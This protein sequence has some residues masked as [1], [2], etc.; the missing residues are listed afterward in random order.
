M[1]ELIEP[2]IFPG[3]ATFAFP[4]PA[5]RIEVATALPDAS[6]A[7]R[8]TVLICHPH[9]LHGGTMQNKVVTTTERALREL[10][11][12]TVRFNFRGVGSSE[13]TYDEGR[14]ESADALELAAWIQRVRPGDALWLAGFSFGSF[15]ALKAAQS[16]PVAQLVSIAPPV[17]RYE[18]THLPPP[19]CPWLV[20]MGD[21]DDVVEPE[22]VFAWVETLSPKPTLER[23]AGAGHFF[24][25]RLIELREAIKRGV[26][27]NL[28][29]LAT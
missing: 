25:G 5:G 10:G 20:L 26:A 23:F 6:V 28:P 14:G 22:A 13:G 15:V 12:A 24:H 18:F 8:G 3:A 9:P 21:A 2:D 1:T 27:A 7:R 17:E 16:L 11:L 4:G 19:K 29:P